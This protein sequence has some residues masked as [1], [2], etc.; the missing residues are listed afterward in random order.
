MTELE[1]WYRKQLGKEYSK[2]HKFLRKRIFDKAYDEIAQTK[3]ALK[4]WTKP[5]R[6]EKAKNEGNPISKKNRS[7]IERFTEKVLESMEK[8]EVPSIDVDISYKTSMDFCNQVRELY[9]V[10]NQSGKKSLPR[11]RKQYNIEIKELD[12][13]LRKIGDYSSKTDKF[14]RK[15]YA[16]AKEAETLLRKIPKIKHKI[17]QLGTA[18]STYEEM[19]EKVEN[20]QEELKNYKKEYEGL[21]QSPELIRLKELNSTLRKRRR[22]LRSFLKFTKAF[23]KLKKGIEDNTVPVHDIN[24]SDLRKYIKAPVR[25]IVAE[26]PQTQNLR[27]VLIRTRL[28]LEDQKNPLKIRKDQRERIVENIN[29]IVNDKALEPKVQE[30][31]D[32][33]EERDQVRKTLEEKGIRDKQ[34][35]LKDKIQ[36][37][38][39]DL[40]HFTNDLEHKKEEYESLLGKVAQYRTFLEDKVKKE[41]G[42]KVKINIIIPD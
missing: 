30:I 11:F 3:I 17:D 21:S 31:L 26:G 1:D 4:G 14:L 5:E 33:Q 9:R 8:I 37:L 38:T 10:Y 39:L 27:E 22:A 16:G 29:D 25:E 6:Y 28:I 13:H 12:L 42:K 15:K 34:E 18:R 23:K 19:Q 41:V 36:T 32:L 2:E 35:D 24:Q 20:M 7:I 40:D